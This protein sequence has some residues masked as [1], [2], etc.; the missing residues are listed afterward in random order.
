VAVAATEF[1]WFLGVVEGVVVTLYAFVVHEPCFALETVK[2]PRHTAIDMGE[3]TVVCR[4]IFAV[5]KELQTG[6]A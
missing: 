2:A 4:Q 3:G 1:F 6:G 5:A